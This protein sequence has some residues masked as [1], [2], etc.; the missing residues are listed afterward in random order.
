[1]S[2]ATAIAAN[3]AG[4]PVQRAKP[5][6]LDWIALGELAVCVIP[7]MTSVALQFPQFGARYL[8]VSLLLVLSVNLLFRDR[9][10]FMSIALGAAPVIGLLRG[11]FFYNS[12]IFFLGL[13]VLL[14]LISGRREI[15]I[16]WS[17]L[18]WR[19]LV[20]LCFVYWW[21]TL[22]L[23]GEYIENIRIGEFALAITGIYLISNQRSYL[24]TT[25]LGMAMSTSALAIGLM[26]V[27]AERL[28]AAIIDDVRYGNPIL[29]GVPSALIV[30]T[31]LADN[32]RWLLLEN[33]PWARTFVCMTAG[34]WLLLSASRGAWAITLFGFLLILLFGRQSRGP[35]FGAL[36]VI[37]IATVFVI[38]TPQGQKVATVFDKTVDS[39][40]SLRNRTSG[41]S[42][43]WE[44]L[45][46]VFAKSP[47]W[48]WGPGSGKDVVW[49]YTGRHLLWHSLYL[50]VIAETGLIGT[51]P[52]FTILALL[53]RRGAIHLRR[54]GEITPLLGVIGFMSLGLS[55]SAF[56]ASS[57]VFLGLAFIT[58]SPIRRLVI[59]QRCVSVPA[60][61]EETINA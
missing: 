39:D 54:Y 48:G 36:A 7:A 11:A 42:V 32:G 2:V 59:R 29:L 25:L 3:E 35:F 34:L 12:V 58:E 21:V 27:A 38:A 28:G 13:G 37:C 1:M 55:V 5:I 30:L 49:L 52:L 17:D 18:I 33:R 6:G 16:V 60:P 43:Q 50:Q 51:I 14:W 44:A 61:E 41:R 22:L 10:R 4:I 57:G 20:I 24:A 31:C 56:D 15:K 46:D 23:T 40:R 47:I 9:Y 8:A 19:T 53:L 45:P 26:P